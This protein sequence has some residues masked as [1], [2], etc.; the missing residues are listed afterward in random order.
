MSGLRDLAKVVD[1]ILCVK[2]TFEE[3]LTRV[4]DVLI[5]SSEHGISIS[6][7][8]FVFGQPEV[9]FVVYV[10]GQD[11]IKA[12]PEKIRAVPEF[13]VPKNI[14]DLQS[15][16]RMVN[17]VASF[18]K[19]I[20]EAR[21]PLRELRSKSNVFSWSPLHLQSF[22]RVKELMTRL[23]VLALFDPS[24]PTRLYVDAAKTKGLGCSLHGKL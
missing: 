11:G 3:H 22:N 9:K 10:V 8:K 24:L 17:Q 2:P 6:P 21:G 13:L 16:D 18:S 23:P 1:G 7:E 19:E 14:P 15:F 4:V 20:N 12:D 5:R